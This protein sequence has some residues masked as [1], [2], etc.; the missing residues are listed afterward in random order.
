M[1][2]S[3]GWGSPNRDLVKWIDSHR[4]RATDAYK[5]NPVLVEEHGRQ[6]DAYRTGGYASRQ[7]VEL[8]QNAA[9]AQ[10]RSRRRG[11]IELLLRDEVLYCANQGDPF[12][13][14]G[15]EAITHAYLSDKREEEIG[16]FGLG[17]KSILGITDAPMVLSRSVA[18]A[19][20]AAET[21]DALRLIA[22]EAQQ[23]P[24]LRLP[25]TVDAEQEIARDSALKGLAPW[26]E[27]IIKIPISK[28]IKRL[29][30]D[31]ETFPSE[32]LLFAPS[33]SEIKIAVED[34]PVREYR[35]EE[36]GDHRWRL[37]EGRKSSTD[38]VVFHRLHRPSEDALA[39]VS[40][41]IRRPEVPVT[42]AAPLDDV[43]SLGVFWAYY[44]LKDETSA[45]G[46]HN[47][48]WRINDDR[49]NLL[50]GKFNDEILD[51]I[52][53]LVVEA[54]PY[55]TTTD[56]PA[57]HFDYLPARGRGSEVAS[58]A[59]KRLTE[60]IPRLA[61]QAASVPDADGALRLPA[62]LR[63]P[64]SDLRLD[65]SS[66]QLWDSAPGRPVLSPH[67]SCFKTTTRRAR[68]R[69]LIRVDDNRAAV[70]EMSAID[71]LE[72]IV[73]DAT[74]EQCDVA[75][76]VFQSV[77]DDVT[78]REMI[79][80]RI[81][82]DTDGRLASLDDT[83]DVFLRGTPLSPAAGI[84]VL[85]TSFLER[86]GV[87]ERLRSIGFENVDPKHE[88]RRLATSITGDWGDPEWRVFWKL[89]QQVSASDAR[90]ILLDHIQSGA[91]LKV[92]CVDGIWQQVGGVVVPGY[93]QPAESSLAVDVS[94]HGGELDLLRSIGVA[95]TPVVSS[96][97]LQDQVLL[98][99]LR[100][101]R[102]EYLSSLPS[103]GR[104]DP[105][106]VNFIE[107]EALTP[108]YILK[109][110]AQSADAESQ[111]RWTQLLLDAQAPETFSLQQGGAS[112]PPVTVVAPHLWAVASYGLL[113]TSWGARPPNASLHPDLSRWESLLPVS[114]WSSASRV[115]VLNSLED[116]PN[117]LWREFLNH[118]PAASVDPFD[119][120]TLLCA[121]HS[122]LPV[123]EV[124][125][126]VPAKRGGAC[127]LV[128]PS[129]VLLAVSDDECRALSGRGLPFVGVRTS[130][131]ATALT[132]AWGC[133]L[134][135]STL[136]VEVVGDGVGEPIVLL[137]RFRS[138]KNFAAGQLDEIEIVECTSVQRV[139]SSSDGTEST[140]VDID[141]YGRTVFYE[142]TV[143]EE[144][145]IGW[146]S[147][148]F[149]LGLGAVDIQRIL[150]AA[151]DQR[152]KE[153][154]AACRSETEPAQKL[155][156]LLPVEVLETRLPTGLLASVR[157]LAGHGGDRQVA[158]LL[159]L[160]HGFNVLSE[161]RKD[162]TSAGYAVPTTFAGSAPAIAFVRGLGFP[163]EFAGERGRNLDSDFLVLGPPNLNKLHPY[164]RALADQIRALVRDRQN[165]GRA[166]L[167]LPTGAGKTRVTVEALTE[168]L[169]H[170]SLPGPILWIAQ[171]EELCEQAVQTWNTV[172]REF[173]N[174]PLRICRLWRDHE[175]ALSDFDATVIVATD[176]KLD[177]VREREDYDWVRAVSAVVIDEAHGATA[178]GITAT[179]KWLGIEG[180]NTTSRPL[181]GLTATPFK[182]TSEDHNNRLATRFGNRLFAMDSDDPYADL[183][184]L[185][186][187]ARVDHK[188]LSGSRFSMDQ[189]EIRKFNKFKDIPNSVLDRI[190]RDHDRT[191]TVLED[192]LTLPRDWPI[193]VFTSSILASQTLSAL[194]RVRDI[195]SDTVSGNTPVRERRRTI[196]AFRNGDIQVLTNCNLLTQG[197]DAPGVRALYVARPT[198]SPNAYIQMVGRGL[199]G[200]ENGGKEECLVVNVED[201]FQAFGETLAY[202]EFDYLWRRHRRGRN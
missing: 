60:L 51:V 160:V 6:E 46:I 69:S 25:H 166:L 19:F 193:L 176:A 85:R 66:F 135:S 47:A 4:Q 162:L 54:L 2:R 49:T 112:T 20:R 38:Y 124:P 68:L 140:S 52:G 158:E 86:D 82:P 101:Q 18:F 167:F 168:S 156:A 122:R 41:A 116:V 26:A 14:Q 161:M 121:A 196:E 141:L 80:A 71:W 202:K 73:S 43:Q 191:I 75:L 198:F 102:A 70:T 3:G 83:A 107:T 155:L 105:T 127:Q 184:R 92:L 62:D 126:V 146:I 16:R 28:N 132:D 147:G 90:E 59:D 145:L 181:L 129:A 50:D 1:Q 179:L 106:T 22:P 165:P 77:K 164:Q 89:V 120:G 143:T 24:V 119:V 67:P 185:G 199:R 40:S 139:V 91:A 31:L 98:E 87:E 130:D 157:A 33:V 177:V 190:G 188:V 21:R 115:P 128:P 44:P 200:P 151:D 78:R 113:D 149:K 183:Q 61:A 118:E 7:V 114:R 186:V 133:A 104:P 159:L 27:T 55:L 53:G 15:L 34:E 195:K 180:R 173:G 13:K 72:S 197:F 58:A 8:V 142:S 12:N 175:I 79:R 189:D 154:I 97:G 63:Y 37:F 171:S 9:D 36:Q 163:A 201:T 5:A 153:R 17:F 84:R 11:R 174:R 95:D 125:E 138:L 64:H 182:G 57:R 99:Y 93:V 136:Q 109:K 152:L 23:F 32:F 88:L 76:Q 96:A 56:D 30:E 169:I 111:K 39:E 35:C 108:L 45:R 123:G 48:P 100:L 134:A 42:Y 74:D 178:V 110:F 131:D 194:L 103:R 148:R 137:D 170:D 150:T 187:L 117:D 65:V 10:S 29:I 144:D 81:L 94:Y 172:W 192:I